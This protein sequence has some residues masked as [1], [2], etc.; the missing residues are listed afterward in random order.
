MLFLQYPGNSGDDKKHIKS[1]CIPEPPTEIKRTAMERH[2]QGHMSPLILQLL[3][4]GE[5]KLPVLMEDSHATSNSSDGNPNNN[6]Q[7]IPDEI[8][9]V[10]EVYQPLRQRVYAIIYNLHHATFNKRQIEES[11]KSNKR[12]IEELNKKLVQEDLSSDE[13]EV[14]RL[15]TE[16]LIKQT[17][18]I[19][20]PPSVE[21]RVREWLPYNNYETPYVKECV[22]L[23][24]PVPT[25]QRLW[26]G[27]TVEDKQKRLHAFLSCM[28]CDDNKS[29]IVQANVPQPMLILAC[30]L[31]YAII[32]EGRS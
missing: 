2:R 30:V 28:R 13:K 17:E 5:I 1:I 4:R 7:Q 20:V 16:N 25:V 31:R 11:I 26:F 22:E 24:W 32:T 19:R 9:P 27:S 21:Y 23:K 15:K 29:L 6:C 14:L 8:P 18:E 10:H 12:K 3:T